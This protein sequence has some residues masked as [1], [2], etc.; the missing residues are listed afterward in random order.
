MNHLSKIVGF[1][2]V[3]ASAKLWVND[4]PGISGELG[5]AL[6]EGED[7]ADWD[8]EGEAG[9]PSLWGRLSKLAYDCLTL[10]L[11]V[12][13]S[14]KGAFRHEMAYT[15]HLPVGTAVLA[16]HTEYSLRIRTQ[17]LRFTR[18]AIDA[19]A[20][21]AAGDGTLSLT[22]TN[23]N[24]SVLLHEGSFDLI[25][26]LNELD[27]CFDLPNERGLDLRLSIS[28]DVE[29]TGFLGS[30]STESGQCLNE[31]LSVWDSVL[32]Q[33]AENPFVD[34]SIR[35]GGNLGALIERN[36]NLLAPAYQ[37]ACG[38]QFM[39]EKLASDNFNAFTNTNRL[40]TEDNRDA[41][42]KQ[43]KGFLT[44]GAALIARQLEGSHVLEAT[45]HETGGW[46]SGS[47]V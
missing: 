4:L 29:L 42:H 10:D 41:Y 21:V 34:A 17:A 5:S 11:E 36:A 20:V 23:E 15:A 39:L 46:N 37:Y 27:Y 33:T 45:H 43:Y 25:A 28:A 44:R 22:V 19:L 40:V 18:L 47:L 13:L 26:G 31:A 32:D 24:G 8:A 30:S 6:V 14:E 16:A 7:V 9:L 35:L 2:P 38:W 1:R 3:T 12:Q